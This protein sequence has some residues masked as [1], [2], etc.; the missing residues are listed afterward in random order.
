VGVIPPLTTE[1]EAAGL[2]LLPLLLLLLLTVA[3]RQPPADDECELQNESYVSM[4]VLCVP[5]P[6]V[7][8]TGPG[9]VGMSNVF[10]GRNEREAD[11]CGVDADG[12]GFFGGPGVAAGAGECIRL[13]T[14][15]GEGSGA[16]ERAGANAGGDMSAGVEADE[17]AGAGGGVGI[18][19]GEEGCVWI[20]D[21]KVAWG[22]GGKVAR[23]AD[24]SDGCTAAGYGD[25]AN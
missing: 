10:D 11:E 24:M 22:F 2:L 18:G 17:G 12:G 16:G 8:V 7:D 1:A 4:V 20:S 23:E 9:A 25:D 14:G 5:V 3:V 15:E 19:E 13:D 6:T 21:G